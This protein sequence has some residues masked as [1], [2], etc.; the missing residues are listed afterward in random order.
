MKPKI[1]AAVTAHNPMQRVQ[2]LLQIAYNYAE[3][4]ADVNL[5]VY[6][7]YEAQEDAET[8][9]EIFSIVDFPV[10]VVVADPG[11]EGWYLTWA[12]KN[13]LASA[14][15]NKEYDYFI[16]QEDDMGLKNHHFNYYRK[17][18]PVLQREGLVPGFVRYEN[19]EGKKIPFDNQEKHPLGGATRKIWGPISFPVPVHLIVDREV[20]FFSQCSNPYYGAMI[21]DWVEANQ[22]IRSAS[23]DHNHSVDRV[24]FRGW[25]IA[26]R[27]SMGTAF[28]NVPE[29]YQH[30]R[31]V[32]IRKV[33][34]KFE[35]CHHALIEHFGDKYSSDF[36]KQGQTLLDCS[37]IFH[38]ATG[39]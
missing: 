33:G 22:Y 7:N 17:W 13:D 25:P 26:D 27:S 39:G 6:I 8:I 28:E 12:H 16:Y 2:N 37:E 19:Y 36:V 18:R 10:T 20:H 34:H 1:W 30:K 15:L 14:V 21:L 35:V 23:F 29:G 4:E 9:T 11:Y 24:G 3:F 38:L 31:C 5:Y 32:P